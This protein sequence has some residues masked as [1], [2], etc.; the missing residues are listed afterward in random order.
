[1]TDTSLHITDDYAGA[2][3][4]W[5]DTMRRENEWGLRVA[6][7]LV[8]LGGIK[9]RTYQNWRQRALQGAPVTLPRDTLER[10]SLLLG[11]YVG[12]KILAPTDR[13]DLAKRW[14]A[15]PNRAQPFCGL[16]V[17]QYALNCGTLIALYSIRRYLDAACTSAQSEQKQRKSAS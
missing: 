17:K 7:Q 10:L 9:R 15:V 16:S 13:P 14:F 11:I 2:A 4:R 5:F 8:L 12:F 1:V 6:E 3:L